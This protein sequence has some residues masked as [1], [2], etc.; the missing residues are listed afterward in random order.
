MG[1]CYPTPTLIFYRRE[2]C[3]SAS[4]GWGWDENQTLGA[5]VFKMR[6]RRLWVRITRMLLKGPSHP[7]P[8][9]PESESLGVGS[10]L[11]TPSTSDFKAFAFT[12]SSAW[13]I[14]PPRNHKTHLV[15]VSVQ[16]LLSPRNFLILRTIHT[17]FTFY[18]PYPTLHFLQYI[19]LTHYIIWFTLSCLLSFC[20]GM[21]APQEH[22]FR[23][24]FFVFIF[25]FCFAL[26]YPQSLE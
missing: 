20:I 8:R 11:S 25:V 16:R 24:G 12:V 18:L 23:P 22:R 3:S 1:C 4:K 7:S 14:L 19:S 10:S 2:E 26:L 17:R 6:V 15:Q 21:L 9:P 13:N 5:Q